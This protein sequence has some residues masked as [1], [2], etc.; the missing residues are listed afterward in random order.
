MHKVKILLS[1]PL[2]ALMA[3]ACDGPSGEENWGPGGLCFKAI[4][5]EIP[6]KEASGRMPGITMT[7]ARL[8]KLCSCLGRHFAEKD[9]QKPGTTKMVLAMF[10]KIASGEKAPEIKAHLRGTGC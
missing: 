6:S 10:R 4:R 8:E 7:D 2:F 9:K 5:T 3:S 1:F